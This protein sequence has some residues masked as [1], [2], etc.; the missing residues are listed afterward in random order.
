MDETCT[1]GTCSRNRMI[2]GL[3]V[4]AARNRSEKRSDKTV[5]Y[6][7]TRAGSDELGGGNQRRAVRTSM[8]GKGQRWRSLWLQVTLI[9]V[10]YHCARYV[11]NT[12]PLIVGGYLRPRVQ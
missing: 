1:A 2:C 4:R 3:Y 11:A 12:L 10:Q 9:T 5:G 8:F 7:T 6:A